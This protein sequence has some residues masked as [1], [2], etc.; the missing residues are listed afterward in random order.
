MELMIL[1]EKPIM[2]H[3]ITAKKIKRTNTL[4]KK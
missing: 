2:K 3:V 1:G 4:F